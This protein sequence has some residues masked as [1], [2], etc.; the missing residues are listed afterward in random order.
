MNLQRL[1]DHLN[2]NFFDG[3]LPKYRVVLSAE[4]PNAGYD[5]HYDGICL[6]ERRLIR[7]RRGMTSENLRRVLIHEM[8]HVRCGDDHG[9]RWQNCM[10]R[11]AAKGE[12]WATEEVTQYRDHAEKWN[13]RIG[14][15]MD[16]LRDAALPPGSSFRQ[17]RR[18]AANIMRIPFRDTYRK[19]PWLKSAWLNA[20]LEAEVE[21]RRRFKFV[22][23]RNQ[24]PER[25]DESLRKTERGNEGAEVT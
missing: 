12:Q 20:C 1:Y 19:L 22:G 16:A 24:G 2:G 25:S 18:G 5:A 6:P 17:V 23:E 4:F 3:R 9:R 14:M 15:L 8:C 21:A 7:L 10:L 11:V 13:D